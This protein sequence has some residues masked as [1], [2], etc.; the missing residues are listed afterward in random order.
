MTRIT[1][2]IRKKRDRQ[3]LA[4]ADIEAFIAGVTRGEV[5]DSQIAALAMAICI[6]GMQVD[7]L[8]ALTLAM[9]DSGDVLQWAHLGLHGP[10]LDK[11]STGGV[12]DL[13]SLLLGPMVAACGGYVPMISG[14]GLGHTGGT[15]D[16]LEAIPGYSVTPSVGHFQQVVKTVGVAIAGQTDRLAPAD[17]RIYSV[18]DVTAT[19]ESVPLITASILSK[20]LCAGLDALVMDVKTGS[21]A[22]MPTLDQSVSLAE[23]IVHVGNGAGMRTRAVLTDMSQSLAPSA[24]NALEVQVA[25]NYLMGKR[26]PAR[27]HQVTMALAEQ[28]LLLGSL[29]ADAAEAQQ[30]LLQ[31]L[32]SGAAF[33]CFDRMCHAMGSRADIASYDHWLPKAPVVRPVPAVQSGQVVS[34]D[35][36]ALGYVVVTL[37]GGRLYPDDRI[38]HR[39]G[40]SGLA[41]LGQSLEAGEP[42]AW[43]HAASDADADRACERVREA[44]TLMTGSGIEYPSVIGP[45]VG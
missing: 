27:L 29:A 26:R 28:M 24:G 37:G 42:V 35:C 13:T 19:V 9:R 3:M 30:K 8:V 4:T 10:L 23:S 11:H 12:G 44:Y 14:R 32:D 6:N 1:E 39:V 7:E 34:I 25:L 41:E 18:R 33:E 43:V 16:K 40:L 38:D 15:L 20:K 5:S 21:G 17:K 31:V 36:R 2:I 22:F 45:L